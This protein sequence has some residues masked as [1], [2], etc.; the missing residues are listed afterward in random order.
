MRPCGVLIKPSATPGGS[1]GGK[2][3]AEGGKEG[4]A[5]QAG[6]TV[7]LDA[8]IGIRALGESSLVRAM[9]DLA[10]GTADTPEG[11]ELAGLVSRLAG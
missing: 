3:E 6:G 7:N 5:A 2:T 4:Q 11:A 10:D 9:I 1:S 8:V